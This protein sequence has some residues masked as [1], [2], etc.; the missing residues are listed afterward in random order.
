MA[1]KFPLTFGLVGALVAAALSSLARAQELPPIRVG[2]T[3][4]TLEG[5]VKVSGPGVAVGRPHLI[6]FL[7]TWI[8][9]VALIERLAETWAA[10]YGEKASIALVYVW[11]RNAE[12]RPRPSP[13]V[14]SVYQ[15]VVPAPSDD[16]D[17]LA[18]WAKEQGA[19]S[20]TWLK[21]SW[22]TEIGIP[23]GFIVGSDGHID[24]IGPAIDAD[25]PLGDVIEGVWKRE[26][27]QKTHDGRLKR[28][29]EGQRLL[30]KLAD[31]M[32][33]PNFP[34]IVV[35]CDEMLA[36]DPRRFAYAAVVKFQTFLF[37]FKDPDRAY[38]YAHQM[39]E[40]YLWNEPRLL[41]DLAMMLD[42]PQ[43]H[44]RRRDWTISR[45]AL[46]R[47][48]VLL[49]D[50]DYFVLASL[51][52]VHMRLNEWNQAVGAQ[53]KAVKVAP[54]TEKERAE[55]LLLRYRRGAG[56]GTVP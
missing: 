36:L 16:R 30:E 44:G 11:A 52:E 31:A 6:I 39:M 47:A 24:W 3:A 32:A 14:L 26:D 15:D 13:E 33:K 1:A 51:A 10:E 38:E 46:A 43:L 21:A 35:T 18:L 2:A 45:K 48:S 19:I 40:R 9:E 50:S 22:M 55:G 5:A 41:V 29:A 37:G 56:G 20:K 34:L 23:V 42:D 54:E 28:H 8:E 27:A 25:R 4:P 7:A 12:D 53:E 17:D 49:N